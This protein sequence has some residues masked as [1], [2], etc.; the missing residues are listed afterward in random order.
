MEI[1]KGKGLRGVVGLFIAHLVEILIVYPLLHLF[2]CIEI[3]AL[4][5]RWRIVLIV[6]DN[7]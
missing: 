2:F 7:A 6:V 5:Y 1:G 4:G 3:T